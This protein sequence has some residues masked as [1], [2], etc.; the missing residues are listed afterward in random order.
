M[1]AVSNVVSDPAGGGA[2]GF[3]WKTYGGLNQ[4]AVPGGGNAI[5]MYGGRRRKTQHRKSRKTMHHKK[6][7]NHYKKSRKSK[8]MFSKMRGMVFGKKGGCGTCGGTGE[9]SAEP[10]ATL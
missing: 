10:S 5:Q 7:F 9:G 3:G 1:S 6:K 4:Q 2:S 8:T